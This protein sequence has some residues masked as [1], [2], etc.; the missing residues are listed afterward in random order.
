MYSPK[1]SNDLIPRV[2]RIAKAK[3]VPMTRLV[4]QILKKGLDKM[5]KNYKSKQDKK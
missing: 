4:N 5:E 2:Y 1:I 3:G